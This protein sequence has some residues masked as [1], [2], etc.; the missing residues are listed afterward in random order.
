M[1]KEIATQATNKVT[2][3]GKLLDTS[4]GNGTLSDGRKYERANLTIRT[5]QTYEGREETSEIPV[6]VF[7][8]QYTAANKPNPAW[9]TIQK[10]R[11]MKTAQ[12]AG[13][14]DADVVRINGA[15]LRENNFVS[16]NGQ[17]ITGWQINTSF[18][19]TGKAN[20]LASFN[21]DIFIMD[22][23]D[24]TNREGDT[25]GRL[26]IKG[27]IVQYGG[28][29]D[30]VEFVVQDPAK[31]EYLARNW[32]I[33]DTVNV[34]GRIRVT[35]QEDTHSAEHS[36]WGEDIPEVSTQMVRELIITTGSDT[37][38]DEE[39]AYSKDDIRKAF[40]VRKAEIEQMQIQAKNGSAA[41]PKA[42]PTATTSSKYS[43]E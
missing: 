42:Q 4:F 23:H 18:V 31:V 12:N 15:S 38:F 6:S 8:T 43:W 5:T 13:L 41:K 3:I 2:I 24:E 14:D 21:F 37:G 20:D 34:R 26:I 27:G 28:R 1:S 11:T 17:L 19:S 22:M 29:L 7:A 30:V 25:T 32:N 39:F 10:L 33:D 35:S 9:D 36:S 40:N 16:R